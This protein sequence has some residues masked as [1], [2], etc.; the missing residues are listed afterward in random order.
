M[1]HG[2]KKLKNKFWKITQASGNAGKV[3][4]KIDP[5]MGK[6]RVTHS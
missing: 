6:M 1:D 2:H 3:P 4:K 5:V